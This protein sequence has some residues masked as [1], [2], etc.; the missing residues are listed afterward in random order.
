M[1]PALQYRLIQPTDQG[2]HCLRAGHSW[3]QLLQPSE[4]LLAWTAPAHLFEP[5]R[6]EAKSVPVLLFVSYFGEGR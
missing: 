2:L 1:S 5:A 6:E 3:L 4:E